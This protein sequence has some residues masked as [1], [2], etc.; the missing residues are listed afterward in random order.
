[1]GKKNPKARTA[2]RRVP[3]GIPEVEVRMPIPWSE[4]VAK[5]RITA[6]SSSP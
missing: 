3:N 6:N 1:M 4:G 5:G 2:F